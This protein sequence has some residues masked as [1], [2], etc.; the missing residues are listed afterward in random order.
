MHVLPLAW[1]IR[2]C[3]G[4]A[5]ETG[6]SALEVA[7]CSVQDF[8]A[9]P[10]PWLTVAPRSLSPRQVTPASAERWRC[11]WE[12]ALPEKRWGPVGKHLVAISSTC[13]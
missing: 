3:L 4:C 10:A 13:Y 6:G 1:H 5:L 8:W 7:P 12:A 11:C 2:R 9:P